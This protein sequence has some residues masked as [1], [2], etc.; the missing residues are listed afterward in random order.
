MSSNDLREGASKTIEN[1]YLHARPD[2]I[3]CKLDGMDE[4]LLFRKFLCPTLNVLCDGW[5]DKLEMQ[6]QLFYRLSR[7][8]SR[9]LDFLDGQRSIVISGTAG[10]GKTVVAREM[11]IRKAKRGDRVLFL[12]Y[13]HLLCEHLKKRMQ[14]YDN[15][16]VKTLD[17][18]RAMMGAAD[19]SELWEKIVAAQGT[20]LYEHIIVDEGQ[21]FGWNV[22]SACANGVANDLLEALEESFLLESP[23]DASRS[24]A[25]FYDRYQLVQGR[26]DA[27][28]KLRLPPYIQN[29]DCKLT[30]YR[31]CRNTKTVAESVM[32]LVGL[33]TY[34]LE[35][36]EGPVNEQTKMYF[37]GYPNPD[38]DIY[39]SCLIT[40]CKELH[41]KFGKEPEKVVIISCGFHSLRNSLLGVHNKIEFDA[42]GLANSG[43]GTIHYMDKDGNDC[44]VPIYTARTF[45]GLEAD[46]VILVDVQPEAFVSPDEEATRLCYTAASRAR[47]SLTMVVNWQE[48]DYLKLNGRLGVEISTPIAKS[49]GKR[50]AKKFKAGSFFEN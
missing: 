32:A 48:G 4:A 26:T 14:G 6:Q 42:E 22:D 27:G 35:A 25:V 41:E 50:L 40:R 34:L 19:W 1:I 7:E 43:R 30:L 16:V 18:F 24:F 11:A 20:W 36:A 49:I 2:K 38:S 39:F 5:D 47:M 29:A 9:V 17:G 33:K 13:N 3:Q 46:A 31:N 23:D 28:A 37:P 45:K 15:I 44:S 10:T 8:Q 21:D 12:C